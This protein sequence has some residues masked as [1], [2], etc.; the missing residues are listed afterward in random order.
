MNKAEVFF[1]KKKKSSEQTTC[2]RYIGDGIL[3]MFTVNIPKKKK[4]KLKY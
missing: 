1:K 2:V 4:K 3:N